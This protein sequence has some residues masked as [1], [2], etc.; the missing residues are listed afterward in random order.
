MGD[1][2][3]EGERAGRASG[4]VRQRQYSGSTGGYREAVA[5]ARDR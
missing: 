1:V 2:G 4:D 3:G 5:A